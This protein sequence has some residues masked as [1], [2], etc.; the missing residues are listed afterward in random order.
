[1]YCKQHTI[2]F[3]SNGVSYAPIAPSGLERECFIVLGLS[4]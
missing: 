4:I 3:A 1:M 2:L